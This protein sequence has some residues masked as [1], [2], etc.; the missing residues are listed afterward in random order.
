[1][2]ADQVLRCAI[3]KVLYSFTYEE[4]AF[5]IVDLHSLRWFCRK[6]RSVRT[7]CTCVESNIHPSHK[8]A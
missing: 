7:D 4:L 1:M 3:V 5:H 8:D 6:G 2:S